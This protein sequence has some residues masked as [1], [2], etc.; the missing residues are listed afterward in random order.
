M[1]EI[2]QAMVKSADKHKDCE[3]AGFIHQLLSEFANTVNCPSDWQV[4][5][6]II[7][8]NYNYG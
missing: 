1:Q 8:E 2:M 4:L 7:V 6:D 5:N 3:M